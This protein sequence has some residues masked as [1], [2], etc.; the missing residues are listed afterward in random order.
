MVQSHGS[1][2]FLCYESMAFLIVVAQAP[3]RKQGQRVRLRAESIINVN[4]GNAQVP[5]GMQYVRT[6]ISGH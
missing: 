5:Y 2:N 4:Q 1:E 3:E 6:R